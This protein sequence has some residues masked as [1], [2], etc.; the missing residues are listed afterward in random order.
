MQ[1]LGFGPWCAEN[2]RRR[3]LPCH[4]MDV[5]K[6]GAEYTALSIGRGAAIGLRWSDR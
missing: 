4:T 6:T 2:D 1:N 3:R 5:L